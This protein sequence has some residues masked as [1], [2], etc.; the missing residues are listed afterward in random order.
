MSQLWLLFDICV[1]NVAREKNNCF[2]C[3][4]LILIYPSLVLKKE[5]LCSCL[6]LGTNA[7]KGK[8]LTNGSTF[9]VK[10]QG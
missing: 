2:T 1:K 6:G 5:S 7:K 9:I 4:V 8:T 3:E 10:S